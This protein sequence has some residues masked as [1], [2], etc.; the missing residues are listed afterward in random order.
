M[1]LRTSGIEPV[2]CSGAMYRAVPPGPLNVV[3]TSLSARPK[4][5]SLGCEPLLVTMMLLGFRSRCAMPTLWTYSTA[6]SSRSNT[7]RRSRCVVEPASHLA[8][9]APST[10]SITMHDPTSGTVSNPTACT[11]PGCCTRIIMS[12]SLRNVS[13]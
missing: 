6:S 8:S 2:A 4:S 12:N 10:H 9:V 13:R 7:R 5:M 3:C 11:T 1:S